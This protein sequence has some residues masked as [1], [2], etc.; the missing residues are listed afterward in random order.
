MHLNLGLRYL[1][2][3]IVRRSVVSLQIIRREKRLLKARLLPQ[4]SAFGIG[5][6]KAIQRLSTRFGFGRRG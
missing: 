4:S 6:L 2:E 3:E 1:S 5:S